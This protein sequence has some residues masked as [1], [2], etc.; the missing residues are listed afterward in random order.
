MGTGGSLTFGGTS[1]LSLSNDTSANALVVPVIGGAAPTAMGAIAFNS[2]TKT[3]V[4]GVGSTAQTLNA[5]R[6]ICYI[7]GSDNTTTASVLTTSDSQKSF[8]VNMIGL[9]TATSWSCQTNSGTANVAL[10]QNGGTA[11]ATA[12]ACGPTVA[13]NGVFTSSPLAANATV[14]FLI[15]S[16]VSGSPTRITVCFAGTVN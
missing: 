13:T 15:N 7:A 11:F 16:I 9:M 14:D 3:L 10:T 4:A 6:T 8:F 2:T 5:P 1:T 12:M